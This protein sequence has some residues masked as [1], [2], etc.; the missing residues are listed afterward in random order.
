MLSS[1]LELL[2]EIYAPLVRLARGAVA[3][4]AGKSRA[5]V[6]ELSRKIRLHSPDLA[7][8]LARL[9]T[10]GPTR[11]VSATID[12]PLDLD[13]RLPLLREEFPAE[14][15]RP[16]ILSHELGDA[17]NQLVEERLNPSKLEA[18]GLAPSR[19][20]LFVGPPGVGKTTAAQAVA[21]RLELPLLTLDLSSVISSFLGKTGS[22]I[23]R[24]F[25]YAR[26]IPCVLFLDEFDA[27]AKSRGDAS[28]IGELKR[29]VTV[30][31]QEIDTWPEESLL[32]AATN[33][34]ESLDPAVWRR[35]DLVARF[36]LPSRL[37]LTEFITSDKAFQGLNPEMVEVL[38]VAYVGHSYSRLGTDLERARRKAALAG[39]TVED[40]VN[41]LVMSHVAKLSVVE[42]KKVA[43]SLMSAGYSQRR[44]ASVLPISRDTIRKMRL[45]EQDDK[46]N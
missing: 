23:R 1:E 25:D 22:N 14:P 46:A 19:S 36:T 4:D 34:E 31:L 38:A 39:A 12:P 37:E 9:V 43:S 2:S 16:L 29:L 17:L 15:G 40:A 8:E 24:V 41:E 26:S 32:L 5:P 35:F 3:A 13:S 45:E 28:D 20:A 33:H 44:V 11:T 27:V 18:V 42:R 10:S 7:Q 30:L 6:R 21:K